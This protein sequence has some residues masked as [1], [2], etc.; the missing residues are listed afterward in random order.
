MSKS[1]LT[2]LCDTAPAAEADPRA[3]ILERALALA[4]A[5]RPALA[6]P[7]GRSISVE[8]AT[9]HLT[10]RGPTGEVELRVCFTS[11]GPVLTFAAA[12]IRLESSGEVSVACE[13]FTVEAREDLA[14]EAGGALRAEGH[15]VDITASRGDVRVQANDD[16]RVTGERIRLNS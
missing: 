9:E 14:L 4:E 11:E 13:R 15:H 16:V 6:L 8:S 2:P 1:K 7:S 12:A 3:P 10:V 5:P